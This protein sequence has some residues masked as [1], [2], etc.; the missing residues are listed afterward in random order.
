MIKASAGSVTVGKSCRWLRVLALRLVLSVCLVGGASLL[1]ERPAVAEDAA[2]EATGADVET[3]IEDIVVIGSRRRDRSATESPVPVD[4]VTADDFVMQG[5]NNLDALVASQVPSY[6]VGLEP[7]SDAASFI[8]PATLRGL[9]PDSTLVLV[10]GKRRHRGAVI[11]WLGSGVSGGAQGADISAI[12]AI[13]L[14]RLEVLRDGASA[15][16]GS[17]AIAG[18]LN[19]VLKDG[20]SGTTLDA[21]WGR[22][23]EGD[24][25]VLTL[26]GNVGLPLTSD[27]FANLSFEWKDS[28]PTDRGVQ[29]GDAQALLNAG[30]VHVRR[31][32]AQIWGSPEYSGDYKLFGN[33]GVDLPGGAEV[34]AFGNWAERQVE[35]GFYFRNPHTR[36]GVFKGDVVDDNGNP[37]PKDDEGK[38]LA[39]GTPTVKVAD[40]SGNLSANCPIIRVEGAFQA[41]G[42]NNPD[43]PYYGGVPDPTALAAVRDHPHCY[44]LYE[45]FRGGFTPQFGGYIDDRALAIGLRGKRGEWFYDLSAAAG[46]SHADFYIYNTINPQLLGRRNDIP[47]Y[48]DA[49]AYT[50][51]D[52]V[53]NFD[54]SRPL[55]LGRSGVP[56]NV[57]LGL[58]YRDE[59]FE[60]AS[61]EPNSYYIDDEY[62]LPEQGFGVGSNGFPGF[63]P[64]D[65]GKSTSRSHAA[66]VDLESNLTERFLLGAAVRYED[67]R[68]FGDTTDG[69]L[70]ARFQV[71]DAVA[72]RSSVSTGFRVPTAGQA[73][74]R[75]VTTEFNKGRLADIATLPPSNPVAQQLG[76][77]P[78]TPEQSTN[79]TMGTVIR[80]NRLDITLDYYN[81]KIE[82][83]ITLTSRFD[84]K[85]ED[86]DAL[87]A[88]GVSDASSFT[89]V[90][91]FTNRQTVEASGIDL[92]ATLPF[93]FWGGES[94][95]TL[96]G[97]WSNVSLTDYDPDFT[98]ENRRRQIEEGRPD[99]RYV[100]TWAHRQGP[101]RFMTRGR[102]YGEHY[103][104]PTNDG[105]VSFYADPRVLFD[106]E[107]SFDWNDSVTM[108]IGAENVLDEYPEENPAGEV[109]GLLYPE[110]SPFGF[111]GG[112]Y[113]VGLKVA[114][115]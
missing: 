114:L 55:S 47:T 62:G 33:F 64:G 16:Y 17:D 28:E 61:G 79:F 5:D 73:T 106:L 58:E 90:R 94:S 36:G 83:R 46:R 81:I 93:A 39:H 27:G 91:F 54:L 70:A 112:Y 44:T 26:A 7:I 11:T 22:H 43:N 66:Y 31:P 13:A 75:N 42:A 3:L 8:R 74:V 99:Q 86:I 67:Y 59:T 76:A 50:E 24:G 10:N 21:R 111:N 69:K 32:T 9:P 113:Y 57:A 107:V 45:K 40:L 53:V 77:T 82:D 97:N 104:A 34:Y 51:T 20:S 85:Q 41:E 23:Y 72:V 109:A 108:V 88:A 100:V 92:V 101:W 110:G 30:N 38:E 35:G 60:V 6:N 98:N 2:P 78:L 87:L 80:L 65:A 68:L 19:F 96:A 12:P 115:P 63:Q 48:Y 56:I 14:D 4:V 15:Q 18:I 89:S 37:V 52:R 71:S 25:D 105:D 102:Y 1:V 95:L 49:G 103:D 84:L 29:R